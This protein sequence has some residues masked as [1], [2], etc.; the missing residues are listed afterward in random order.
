MT[1]AVHR[2]AVETG[3][4]ASRPPA[5]PSAEPDRTAMGQG[6]TATTPRE[7]GLARRRRWWR[8]A[9]SLAPVLALLGLLAYGF[10]RDP[11]AIRSPL[12]GT[13]APDFQITLF[14]GSQVRLSD[15]RSRVVF[16]N[17]WAS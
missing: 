6:I 1:S 8:M 11:R 2:S 17:F 16:L 3:Q 15:F 9:L 7:A 10:T 5:A 4:E 14:D 13:P 12:V